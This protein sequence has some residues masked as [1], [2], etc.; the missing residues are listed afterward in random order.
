MCWNLSSKETSFWKKINLIIFSQDNEIST[1]GLRILNEKYNDTNSVK[2]RVSISR[3]IGHCKV[4]NSQL[5]A[6]FGDFNAFYNF[7]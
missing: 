1:S 7:R 4:I 2:D 5:N 3:G 6:H